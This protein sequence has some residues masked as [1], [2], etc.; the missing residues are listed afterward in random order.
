[1][2]VS[3]G[4]SNLFG[5]YKQK[6]IKRKKTK[7][8]VRVSAEISSLFCPQRTHSVERKHSNERLH[9]SKRTHSSGRNILVREQTPV[10]EHILVR[11][12]ICSKPQKS[13]Q[14]LRAGFVHE[15]E[16]EGGREGERD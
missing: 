13:P 2:R 10:R 16:R 12:H 9:S 5:P 3:A 4:I 7:K 14:Q 15:R 8:D 6:G 11:G 1:M